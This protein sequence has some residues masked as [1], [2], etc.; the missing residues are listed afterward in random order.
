MYSEEDLIKRCLNNEPKAHD[1]FYRR[2]APKMYGVCLRFAKNQ[3][4]A[5]DILQEGFIKVFNNLKTFRNEGSLEGWVRRTIVNTA[6]NLF[7][8]NA[9]YLK[10]T[11]IEQAEV[12]QNMEEGSLDKI[13]VEELL[14]LVRELPAGYRM[15]FNLNILEGYTHK[16]ISE[17]LAIS[18]N[19]SKSQLS[20]ARQSLQKKIS[21]LYT[22][23]IK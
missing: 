7:K 3:M 15:V 20:R 18:E 23:F 4:E 22:G 19:T 2:Y 17:L 6:I 1:D 14:A 12:V 9:K 13:S 10:D 16:E 5:D 11:G 8:K 21:E